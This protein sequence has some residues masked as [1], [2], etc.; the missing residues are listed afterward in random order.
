MFAKKF[1]LAGEDIIKVE[2]LYLKPKNRKNS[3]TVARQIR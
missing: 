3:E 2:V 1:S